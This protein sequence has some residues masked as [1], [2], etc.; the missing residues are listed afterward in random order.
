MGKLFEEIV[1]PIDKINSAGALVGGQNL[2]GNGVDGRELA[3][4]EERHPDLICKIG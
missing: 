3:V 2:L 4:D 1:Y